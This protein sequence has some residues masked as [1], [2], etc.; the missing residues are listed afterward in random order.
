VVSPQTLLRWHRELM[1]RKWTYKRTPV[2]GRP[3]ITGEV[4]ELILRMGRENN[5]W[6]CIRIRGELA[7]LDIRVSATTIRRLLRASG[8]PGSPEIRPH[9]ERVPA[10]PSRG[11]PRAGLL[12]CRNALA[13]HA[14]R[15]FRDPAPVSPRIRP[16]RH[17][18]ARLSLPLQHP[19]ER[20]GRQPRMRH[21]AG[22]LRS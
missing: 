11:D 20:C 19:F 18:E 15:P 2:G 16:R 17:N 4:R 8:W 5:R 12:H 22:L 13:S 1:R 14:V 21:E 6:G 9:L 3:A 7:K 10:F